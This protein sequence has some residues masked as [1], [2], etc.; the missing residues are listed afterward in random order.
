MSTTL[1]HTT[2]VRQSLHLSIDP[3][4]YHHFRA[5][6]SDSNTSSSDSA[7]T[8]SETM[9]SSP[10]SSV[11]E[12][13]SIICTVLCM[14]DFQSDN[15]IHLS[16]RRNEMLDIITQEATGW[17][18]AMRRG[19][20]VVG[21]IPQAFVRPLSW[22]MAERLRSILEELR[23]F[24]Y[25]AEQ[26]YNSA[27]TS[28]ISSVLESPLLIEAEKHVSARSPWSSPETHQRPH[29]P[30]SPKTPVPHPPLITVPVRRKLRNPCSMSEISCRDKLATLEPL[31][32]LRNPPRRHYSPLASEHDSDAES[33]SAS[34]RRRLEK[35][36]QLTGSEEA[37]SFISTVQA[38]A[39]SPWYMK[40][41][42]S[43]QLRIDSEGQ[44]RSGTTEALVEKL[45]SETSKDV[46][47]AAQEN[48]FRNA[49]LMTFRTFMTADQLFTAL[50]GIYA[51]EYPSKITDPEYEE[52]REKC[53]LPTQRIVLTVFTMWLEDHRLLEEEPHIAQHLTDFLNDVT[54]PLAVTAKLIVKSI[55]RLTFASPYV[56]SPVVSPR[57]RKKSRDHKGDLLRLDPTD[58]AE[59][60]SLFEYTL[61][62]KI[63]P[64][65]C[66]LYAK[67]PQ[68]APNLNTFCA[69]HDKL[70]SWVTFSILNNEALGKRAD[71]I[72]LW[73]KVAEKC[74]NM[75]NFASMSALITALSSVVITRLHLTW[76]HVGRKT[77]LDA[78]LKYNEPSGG[79]AAFR[80]LQSNAEGPCVPFV[81]M[82]LTDI[83]HT[84]DQFEDVEDDGRIVFIK[85]QRWYET[86]TQM[87]RHQSKP[88]NIGESMS[89][90]GFISLNLRTTGTKDWSLAWAKSQD[91]QR[92]ELEH[93]DI[94]RGLEAAGF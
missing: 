11:S 83:A 77:N 37:V 76:A 21:W 88:Y 43:D 93:A 63:T 49:F 53:S 6:S 60:L 47:K 51:M 9:E 36:K 5:S 74:R 91:V 68:L 85:R 44:V 89:I 52:W 23:V 42:H 25:D 70:A 2:R 15:P 62:N 12:P 65:D 14:Y 34:D 73:I 57:R 84:K 24:E 72:D 67:S 56:E 17:W 3:S 20:N 27:P 94:R 4:P 10:P 50:V 32:P 16:F 39:N 46:I 80:N 86:I 90:R 81:G 66:L 35:I 92:S 26:L 87:L 38:Q 18:A 45:T 79:F 59:Q 30:P 71:T 64:Q 75:N 69:T 54:P 29:H 78:L 1:S 33:P 31:S 41:R 19:G 28:Q 8:S 61:Y 82:Y 58:L 13:S 22:E 55:E 7:M 40:S 48:T